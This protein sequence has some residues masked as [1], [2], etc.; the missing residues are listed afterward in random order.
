MPQVAPYS[1]AMLAIVARSAS[2]R[3]ARPGPKNST[4][5]P[6]TPC[7]RSTCVTVSTTSVAVTPG[8]GRPVNL[9]P[10]TCGIFPV[11]EK[12]I[13]YLRLTGREKIVPLVESY[14]KAQGLWHDGTQADAPYS[15]IV[16]FDLPAVAPSLAGPSRPQDRVALADV[17]K[18][19]R[20]ALAK[21][22]EGETA[23]LD[24]EDIT[25]GLQEGGQPMLIAPEYAELHPDNGMDVF[26]K[27]RAVRQ[28]NGLAYNLCHG[29]VV[30]A[31]IT[32]CTNTSNPSVLIAAG[33]LARNAVRR[34]LHVKPWV[35]TSLAPG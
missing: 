8:C 33:L 4:N 32:S 15:S 5:L 22:Y 18:S 6:T 17:R 14:Y 30:I 11:D 16:E 34:G 21:Q 23:H 25:R 13:A 26:G 3:W 20:Q 29:S 31:A 19:F 28:S 12:T 24:K 27:C 7:L 35:K 9:K 10:T 1:G 2:A